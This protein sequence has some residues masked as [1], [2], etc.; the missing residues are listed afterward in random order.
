MIRESKY[1]S[2]VMKKHVIKELMMTK[3]DNKNLNNSTKCWLCGRDY[4]VNNVKVRDNCHITENYRDSSHRDCNINLK[5]NHK[6]PIRNLKSY[7]FHLI[8]QEL[9][10]SVWKQILYSMN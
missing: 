1:C 3:E 6:V 10:N 9:G 7:D 8:M 4:V 5:L 2:D